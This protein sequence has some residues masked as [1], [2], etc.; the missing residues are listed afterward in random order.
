MEKLN[1]VA[2][3]RRTD[4]NASRFGGNLR[5]SGDSVAFKSFVVNVILAKFILTSRSVVGDGLGRRDA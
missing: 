2:R 5:Q 3:E 4:R 1:G